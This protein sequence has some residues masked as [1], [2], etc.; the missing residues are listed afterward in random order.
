MEVIK[1]YKVDQFTTHLN[2][3]NP[4]IRFMVALQEEEQDHQHLPVLDIDIIRLDDG[5][6]KFKM[7]KKKT[8]MDQYLNW[9]SHHLLQKLGVI[10][11][12]FDC[13]K[14]LTTEELD[15]SK[16]ITSRQL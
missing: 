11:T 15:R 2:S 5:S 8:H 14:A 12:L 13:A 6:P 10:H 7:Y 16:L 4:S 1:K 3:R 9:Q